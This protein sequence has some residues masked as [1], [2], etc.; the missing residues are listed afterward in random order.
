MAP[1]THND[2]A[3][4]SPREQTAV[5]EALEARLAARAQ[6]GRAEAETDSLRARLYSFE[7][8]YGMS[9]VEM[10]RRVADGTLAE[11]EDVASW[12]FWSEAYQSRVVR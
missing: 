7:Q 6:A 1:L 10:H 11:N 5:F 3:A 4:L 12:L 2:F 8:K 9:T